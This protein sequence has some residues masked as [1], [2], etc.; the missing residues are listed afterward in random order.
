M[1]WRRISIARVLSIALAVVVLFDPW[2]VNAPGFWLSFAA[3]DVIAY[4]LSGK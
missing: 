4:A 1:E 2:S 3:V